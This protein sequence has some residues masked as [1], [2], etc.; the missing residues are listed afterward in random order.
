MIWRFGEFV[1][2]VMRSLDVRIEVGDEFHLRQRPADGP[3]QEAEFIRLLRLHPVPG[4]DE[5]EDPGNI[6]Q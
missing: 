3:E 4:P 6:H 1:I 2:A 5:P